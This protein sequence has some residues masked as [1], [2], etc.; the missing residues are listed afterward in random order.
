MSK[1]EIKKVDY[2]TVSQFKSKA[3][4]EGVVMDEKTEYLGAFVAGSLVGFVGKMVLPGNKIRFKSDWVMPFWRGKKVYM[5]LFLNR[6]DEVKGSG[7]KGEV[8]AFCTQLSL[9]I[10]LKNGFEITSTLERGST[11]VTLTIK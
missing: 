5:A 3:A 6:L 9:P 4:K 11:I 8:N 2:K 7:Y 10:Y 1:I